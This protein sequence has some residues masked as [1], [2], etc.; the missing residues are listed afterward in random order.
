MLGP[1][2]FLVFH[3]NN[4]EAIQKSL[5]RRPCWKVRWQAAQGVGRRAGLCGQRGCSASAPRPGWRR[6][7]SAPPR[8]AQSAVEIP[9]DIEE[10]LF[11]KTPA[12]SDQSYIRFLEQRKRAV[13]R[14]TDLQARALVA[15][16]FNFVWR[17]VLFVGTDAQGKSVSLHRSARVPRRGASCTA[18]GTSISP[19]SRPFSRPATSRRTR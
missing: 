19:A 11:G 6:D 5:E 2:R 10:Y 9:E 12:P 3:G 4:S 13:H 1:F 16:E 14:L 15:Q 7:R 17:P 8:A 18:A